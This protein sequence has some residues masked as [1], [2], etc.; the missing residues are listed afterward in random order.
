M[1]RAGV[2]V[3]KFHKEI[4]SALATA[5]MP[6]GLNFASG[7]GAALFYGQLAGAAWPGILASGACF[8]LLLVLFQRHP[9]WEWGKCAVWLLSTLRLILAAA[10]LLEA[11]HIGALVLPLHRAGAYAA[12]FAALLC[13][14]VVL[15]GRNWVRNLNAVYGILLAAFMC[16]LQLAPD[17]RPAMRMAVEL[18]LGNC[19]P[20]ALLLGLCHGALS[21][22][23]AGPGFIISARSSALAGLLYTLLLGLSNAVFITRNPALLR[24]KDPFAAL[25]SGWGTVG[26]CLCALI[27]FL[28]CIAALSGI[29]YGSVSERKCRNSGKNRC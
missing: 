9:A 6:L 1:L 28:G 11:A 13:A 4:V 16:L 15:G 14:A 21:A 3:L 19:I 20:A 18:K 8:S 22:C 7:R 23:M 5:A 12:A 26:F 10:L 17:A 2:V 29:L 27:I 24:L 25:A